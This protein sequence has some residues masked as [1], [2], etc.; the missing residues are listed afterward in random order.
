MRLPGKRDRITIVGR[1]GGG[2]TQ[3]ALWHL[4]HSNFDVK[5]WIIF[6]YKL[7]DAINSIEGAE[8][9][10][11][12]Y[13]PK[14]PGIYVTHPLPSQWREVDNYLM[15]I[16]E[17]ENIGL[18]CDEGYMMGETAGFLSCLTQG[19]SKR[20]P[21]IILAQRPVDISRFVFSEAQYYQV[22]SLN[23][24][25]DMK[26]VNNF[27]PLPFK[28]PLKEFHSFYYDVKKDSLNIV[29]P[30]PPEGVTLQRI[31]DR[32]KARRGRRYL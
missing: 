1:T 32:L 19:R 16:W 25:R 26:T 24:K 23:D 15:G 5:P 2:K 14:H 22:F 30:V 17:R 6:D 21:M 12:G 9:I 11:V 31:E 27:A 10:D 18:Y 13:I 4:S 28:V 3:A 7:E 29:K 8:H 20:I